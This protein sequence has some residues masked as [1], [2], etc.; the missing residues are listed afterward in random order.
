MKK[1]IKINFSGMG[2]HF[3]PN[4]NFITDILKKRYDVILSN[5]PDYVICSVNSKDYIKYDCIR[6]YYTAENLVTDFNIYDY[7]IGFHYI[8]FEDRYI[9]YPLYLVDGFTAYD[10]DNYASDL[11]RAVHK[12]ETAEETLKMKT[13]FC[14][15][16]YSNAEAVHCRQAM[17]DALSQYKQVNSG[18]RYL[19]NIGK[20]VEN[21]LEFQKKHKFVIAF[22]NSSTPGYTT[23]KIVHAFSAGAV[24][25]Y[26][27]NPEIT[28]EFTAGSFI[29][30]HDYGLTEKGEPEAIERIV[31]EVKRL[32]QDRYSYLQMLTT[33][34][35]T[36]TNDVWT[37]KKAFEEFLFNIFDQ[38]KD[39]AFRR[40]RFYWG[41]RYERKQKIGNGFYWQC[42]K[43]I[44]VRNAVKNFF[45]KK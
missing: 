32:D 7:G 35:F 13:D 37:Q 36:S 26:W 44:P 24:P 12:H 38:D 42:R 15:F 31:Q 8:N 27:G 3:N 45:K 11:E 2:G 23:E 19:N 17:F 28:K 20:P 4:S 22:E 30:C 34:A 39:Q 41:E 40:N 1:K 6:I 33:P 10:G 16:V 25:I 29:N 5:D 21:K 43:A 9:R 18:G 14:S